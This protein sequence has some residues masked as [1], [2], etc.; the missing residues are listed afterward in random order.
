MMGRLSA[1]MILHSK[2]MEVEAGACDSGERA[3]VVVSL[4][5]QLPAPTACSSPPP[6]HRPHV[7]HVLHVLHGPTT[8]NPSLLKPHLLHLSA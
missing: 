7:L 3:L 6:A 8:H 1:S 2:E 4:P 5:L